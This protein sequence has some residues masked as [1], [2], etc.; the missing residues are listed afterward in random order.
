MPEQSLEE[1]LLA[2]LVKVNEAKAI[3]AAAPSSATEIAPVTSNLLATWT[4]IGT[5]L[6][7]NGLTVPVEFA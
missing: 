4:S 6:A 3:I 2:V 5:T 1:A 7:E